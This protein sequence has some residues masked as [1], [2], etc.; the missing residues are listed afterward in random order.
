MATGSKF[1]GRIPLLFMRGALK[2]IILCSP[3][4]SRYVGNHFYLHEFRLYM[5]NSGTRKTIDDP[6]RSLTST[7]SRFLCL[8]SHKSIRKAISSVKDCSPVPQDSLGPAVILV[9]VPLLVSEVGDC[10]EVEEWLSE[11]PP[12]DRSVPPPFFAV[13]Q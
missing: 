5:P 10:R 4:S 9:L 2:K 7:T 11:R 3:G 1:E 12:E 8:M 13:H 6:A